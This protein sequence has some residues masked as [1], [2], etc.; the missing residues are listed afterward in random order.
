MSLAS[1]VA[2]SIGQARTMALNH[3][4]WNALRITTCAL[5]LMAIP[6]VADAAE[7][8][9]TAVSRNAATD[10]LVVRGRAGLRAHLRHDLFRAQG[11]EEI[12][13]NDA[14]GVSVIRVPRRRLHLVERTLRRSGY[15][16]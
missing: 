4:S 16:K 11:T 15:F 7:G 14:L 9:A 13:R 2:Q 10:L 8:G 6:V 12:S 5:V 3:L 1:A